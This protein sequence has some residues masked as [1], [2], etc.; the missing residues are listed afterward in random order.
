MR[1]ANIEDRIASDGPR[2]KEDGKRRKCDELQVDERL[3]CGDLHMDICITWYME[4][5]RL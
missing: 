3:D 4:K 1:A 5:S 2:W